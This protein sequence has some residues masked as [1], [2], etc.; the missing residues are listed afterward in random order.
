MV[1]SLL[2]SLTS[3]TFAELSRL[4]LRPSG[5]DGLRVSP[6]VETR[7]VTVGLV[8]MSGDFGAIGEVGAGGTS[9]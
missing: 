2:T 7:L 5:R 3:A 9:T 8:G 4:R 1:A 6:D